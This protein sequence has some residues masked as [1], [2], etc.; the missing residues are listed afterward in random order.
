MAID[1]CPVLA[2]DLQLL[3]SGLASLPTQA[4]ECGISHIELIAAD[5]GSA[6]VIRHTRP[7]TV[8]ALD[9]LGQLQQQ[10]G[11][12]LWLQGEKAA[13]LCSLT[14][15]AVDPRLHY[16]LE[17][18]GNQAVATHLQLGFHPQDF[19]QINR[20][21]NQQMVAQALSWLNLQGTET[22]LDLFCGIGNF[23]LPL[24]S[25]AAR[26][27]GIEA[28]E[29]MVLRG[30]ENALVNGVA[31][32]EFMALD[33]T[34]P[35]A[36]SDW[37]Q[38][39]VDAVLLDPPRAGAQQAVNWIAQQRVP[40]ILYVSCDPASLARDAAIL[41]EQD[42]RLERLGIMDMFPQTAHV[43]S[44]ALFV[45]RSPINASGKHYG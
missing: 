33:L 28:V 4:K 10:T 3:L 43:E 8:R 35:E 30:R 20:S 27:I 24:A 39:P 2:A 40:R 38:F 15:D 9:W 36:V 37:N 16:Q 34:A 26:V 18:Q 14:G 22:V 19:T 23:T 44:M 5:E 7:M 25:Q 42:Y 13:G 32:C 45:L 29:A 17:V 21:I 12:Q 6:A 1:Q 41:K 11:A 31:N